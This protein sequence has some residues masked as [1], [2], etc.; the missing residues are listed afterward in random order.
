MTN[1]QLTI[2]LAQR[3][4]GWRV[5]PD[6]FMTG[7]RGWMTRWRFQPTEKLVDALR[8]LEEAAPEEYSMSID[9]NGNFKVRIQVAGA[10]GEAHG[11]SQ[12]RSITYAIARALGLVRTRAEAD[13]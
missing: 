2:I 8:L 3:V 6:R 7:N 1:E 9:G 10:T 12:P 11:R 13:L 4:M 5:G